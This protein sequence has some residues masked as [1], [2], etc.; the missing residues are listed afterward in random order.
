[1]AKKGFSKEMKSAEVLTESSDCKAV[2]A[3]RE[4][5]I[6]LCLAMSSGRA[7]ALETAKATPLERTRSFTETTL[8]PSYLKFGAQEGGAS[9]SVA[10]EDG[11]EMGTVV[12]T[13]DSIPAVVPVFCLCAGGA[14]AEA[15]EV[16]ALVCRDVWH[17]VVSATE[18][19]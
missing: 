15:D 4:L 18:A 10:R 14:S 17:V 16:R 3:S 11:A 8:L 2:T 5:V 19:R 6:S 12:T 1:M 13:V 9:T 7:V